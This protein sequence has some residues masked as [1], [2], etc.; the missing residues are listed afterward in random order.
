MTLQAGHDIV[1]NAEL[2]SSLPETVPLAAE[3][4][5]SSAPA[6]THM[7]EETDQIPET[8][9]HEPAT[10]SA[11]CSTEIPV[12]DVE[13]HL[14]N[15]SMETPIASSSMI[16][17]GSINNDHG[18]TSSGQSVDG[19]SF[20]NYPPV[21]YPPSFFVN[22]FADS[23][24]V[25][26]DEDEENDNDG[27]DDQMDEDDNAS[28]ISEGEDLRVSSLPVSCSL[29]PHPKIYISRET[30]KQ[31]FEATLISKDT[32]RMAPHFLKLRIHVFVW[33]ALASWGFLSANV[34]RNSS[35]GALHR[36]PL[37][38][39]N[40]QSWIPRLGIHGRYNPMS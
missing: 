19:S 11:S 13:E 40:G 2:H 35:S 16:P 22:E 12:R 10:P 31:P 32:T 9:V 28:E 8:S 39:E 15:A 33:T 20:A 5:K 36:H 14:P 21:V 27:E 25:D 24:D 4:V 18:A 34:M 7:L 37:G 3:R 38:K 23:M 26:E 17:M 1:S 29:F 30:S 6:D